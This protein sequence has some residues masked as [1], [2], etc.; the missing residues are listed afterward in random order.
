[1]PIYYSLKAS[2]A[3]KVSK[4]I[5]LCLESDNLISAIDRLDSHDVPFSRM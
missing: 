1:M 5:L 4:R 2:V 3:E